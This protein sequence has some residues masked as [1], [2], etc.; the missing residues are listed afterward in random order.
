MEKGRALIEL[1]PAVDQR[2]GQERQP[3]RKDNWLWLFL[4][5]AV[6]AGSWFSWWLVQPV[7]FFR[8]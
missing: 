3:R 4:P 7:N 1:I 5:V 8:G 6:S 2:C